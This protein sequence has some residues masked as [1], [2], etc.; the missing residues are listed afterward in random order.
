MISTSLQVGVDVIHGGPH[1]KELRAFLCFYCAEHVPSSVDF[2]LQTMLGPRGL[3][4]L[5]PPHL[6]YKYNRAI[7]HFWAQMKGYA[8]RHYFV[9]RLLAM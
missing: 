1:A 9:L 2:E 5:T 3:I 7:E 8:R 6:L 4:L